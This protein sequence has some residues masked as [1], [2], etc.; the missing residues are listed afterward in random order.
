MPAWSIKDSAELIQRRDNAAADEDS[1]VTLARDTS[2]RFGNRAGHFTSSSGAFGTVDYYAV[3]DN[4][5]RL[6]RKTSEHEFEKLV[7]EHQELALK[8]M[9]QGLTRSERLK[10]SLVQWR[11]DQLE[12]AQFG[13][14]LDNWEQIAERQEELEKALATFLEAVETQR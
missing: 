3:R 12:D 8:E 5:R 1:P 11:L 10:W 6:A 14:S 13:E 2:R 9:S 4:N 7:A